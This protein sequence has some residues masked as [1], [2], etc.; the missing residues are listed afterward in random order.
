MYYLYILIY[1]YM[2][3]HIFTCTIYWQVTIYSWSTLDICS[4][5]CLFKTS[6]NTM[7]ELEKKATL[8]LLLASQYLIPPRLWNSKKLSKGLNMNIFWF[9]FGTVF[10][11]SSGTILGRRYQGVVGPHCLGF[12]EGKQNDPVGPPNSGTQRKQLKYIRK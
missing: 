2:Y 1:I 7:V 12:K 8:V 10:C 3:V 6:F 5:R 4:W 9:S 11:F